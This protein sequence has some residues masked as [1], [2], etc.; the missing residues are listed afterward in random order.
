MDLWNVGILSQHHTASQ[1]GRRLV[2][3]S[4]EQSVIW[5]ANGHSASQEIPHP[6]WNPMVHYSVHNSPP[7]VPILSHMNPIHTFPPYFPNTHSTI[8]PSTSR[9]SK[10]CLPL[11]FLRLRFYM[12]FPI[13]RMRA[14]CPAHWNNT[15]AILFRALR[16]CMVVKFANFVTFMTVSGGRDNH[17]GAMTILAHWH[18]TRDITGHYDVNTSTSIKSRVK[19]CNVKSFGTLRRLASLA[20]DIR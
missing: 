1:S 7:L 11:R 18:M 9:Y 2:I 15:K 14:T 10:W 16:F 3:N 17:V 8:F 12:H 5:E 4:V 19:T 20:S 6:T 13:S